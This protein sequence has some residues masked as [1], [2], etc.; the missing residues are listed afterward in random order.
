MRLKQLEVHGFKTFANRTPFLFKEGIT[1]IVGPNGCGKSNIADAIRWALGEQSSSTLRTKKTEDLIFSGS[2]SR[3]RQGMAEVAMTLENPLALAEESHIEVSATGNG[4]NGN[5]SH[6]EARVHA[7]VVDEI[8]NAHPT[9]V[10]LTRRAYRSG[11]NEY[12]INRQ[13]VR[14][15]DV[16]ELLQRWGL[17]RH[18]YAVIGQGL[19]DQALS[20]RAEERRALFEEAAGIGLYQS[21]KASALEKL[22]ETRQNLIRVN[23]IINEIAPRLPSLARQADRAGKYE[24]VSNSLNEKLRLWYAFQW[25]NAQEHLQS[26]QAEETTARERLA[27][28]RNLLHEQAVHLTDARRRAQI[29]RQK[30]VEH[31][32]KRTTL[33]AMHATQERELAVYEE[34]LNSLKDRRAQALLEINLLEDELSTTAENTPPLSDRREEHEHQRARA[35]ARKRLADAR[36]VEIGDVRAALG[37]P[38]SRGDTKD[39]AQRLVELTDRLPLYE[40]ALSDVSRLAARADD[41]ARRQI[42]QREQEKL[43]ERARDELNEARTSLALIERDLQAAR[44][45]EENDRAARVRSAKDLETKKLRLSQLDGQINQITLQRDASAARV[46][47]LSEEVKGIADESFPDEAELNDTERKQ[48]ELEEQEISARSELMVV[49]EI[50]NRA[51]L[52]AERRRA[53]IARLE[54]EIEDDLGPV[55]LDSTAPRQLRLRLTLQPGLPLVADEDNESAELTAQ[56][57]ITLPLVQVLPDNFDKDIRR[58]KN[59]MKYIGN[60]NPNAP[61]EYKELKERHAFLTEQAEDLRQ[62]TERLQQATSELDEIMQLRFKETFDAINV[63][64]KK[65]FTLLFGGGSARLELTDPDNLITSG[66]EITAKPPGKRPAQLV[67]LSGGERALTAASLLF[68]I[69]SASPTPFC[70][71]DEVDAALDEANVGRFRDVLKDLGADTQFIVITHNRTTIESA[72]AIYG[73]S[74]GED[75]VSQVLS[76]QLEAALANAK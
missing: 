23:D 70:V 30:L 32:R 19:V 71:L 67:L 49:E 59:Q 62:A 65:Y 52:E 56:E 6:G 44:L 38:N 50:Y 40:Q 34:R 15:R 21:K 39:L 12:L 42:S 35:L 27:D 37:Q 2:S 13:R 11:E 41:L 4:K 45:A 22:E 73:V 72:S 8:I 1:A 14:L 68:A 26:A 60:V 36:V 57:P 17:A 25:A 9:E 69:L 28:R 64:F 63:E 75:G 54:G 24:S 5:D 16:Q 76:L 33:E 31:R 53:E 46:N 20:L 10:T 66:I 61:L 58:L 7:S 3:P 18:T 48:N 29:L 74:M 43:L 47:E 51:V 55:E